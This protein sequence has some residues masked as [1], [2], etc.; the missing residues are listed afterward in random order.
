[1]EKRDRIL[2]S[3]YTSFLFQAGGLVILFLFIIA[4]V[5]FNI[6]Q[7]QT[8]ESMK[9][10]LSALS[11][12]SSLLNER[13]SEASAETERLTAE[14]DSLTQENKELKNEVSQ[15]TTKMVR[16]DSMVKTYYDSRGTACAG[17]TATCL[18]ELF[19]EVEEAQEPEC[20]PVEDGVC[21]ET[22]SAA[23]DFDCCAEKGYK[24]VTGKGCY[25]K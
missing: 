12:D 15:L 25:S 23:T 20:S 19:K 16:I 21:L 3:Y 14:L 9:N 13:L 6:N 1:M 22:C 17:D 11:E 18:E 8:I 24:W 10:N 2:L 5:L 7:Y 4:S